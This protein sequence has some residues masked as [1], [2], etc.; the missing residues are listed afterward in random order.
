MAEGRQSF[1]VLQIHILVLVLRLQTLHPPVGHYVLLILSGDLRDEGP[2]APLKVLLEGAES[3][4]V[5]L[6]LLSIELLLVIFKGLHLLLEV[7]LGVVVVLQL[8]LL[9]LE[10]E[11]LCLIL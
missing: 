5:Y 4:V 1:V 3:L 9:L 6:Q 10:C 7:N 8:L 11:V 2:L